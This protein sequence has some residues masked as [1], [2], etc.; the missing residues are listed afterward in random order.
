MTDW[1]QRQIYRA[2]IFGSVVNVALSGV[3]FAAGIVGHSSAM[4]ADAVH[5]LSDLI[6]D[7]VVLLFVRI[8]DKPADED[9]AYGHGKYETLATVVIGLILAGA[10]IGILVDGVSKIIAFFGGE[11]MGEPNWWALGAAILSIVC[12]EW[13]FRYTIR[14]AGRTKSDVL[15]ANAWHHRSDAYT[16]IA[17]VAGIGGAMLLG[18]S[19]R[20]LDP[21][22][23]AAVSLF[24][25]YEAW[26]IIR[27]AL[28]E[29]LE[30]ALPEDQL[31][32]IAGIIEG[33]PGVKGFH[34]L[35]TRRVGG[36]QIA[37]SVHIK[38]DPTI[39]LADAHTIATAVEKAL[40]AA[41]GA[42]TF[43]SVHMEPAKIA[44]A[45]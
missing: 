27:P 10:G 36:G 39:S 3:K 25:I 33:V 28:D 12:K 4:I 35:R 15:V 30:K 6:S 32:R 13:A 31:L 21:L 22:A 41:F 43:I 34:H 40:R 29:L 16:S 42:R 9:H 7:I 26:Q 2:T 23:A 8:A 24:I 5:S 17:T 44:T 20:V 38:M 19:M 37:I 11:P 45:R 18:P 1:R 14:V